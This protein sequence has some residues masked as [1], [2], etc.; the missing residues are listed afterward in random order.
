MFQVKKNLIKIKLFCFHCFR[1]R[2]RQAPHRPTESKAVYTEDDAVNTAEKDKEEINQAVIK[3]KTSN[4]NSAA[5]A[6]G[7]AGEKHKIG[8]I[9]ARYGLASSPKQDQED[10]DSAGVT[11]PFL[12]KTEQERWKRELAAVDGKSRNS[13]NVPQEENRYS[14]FKMAPSVSYNP[15]HESQTLDTDAL[16]MTSLS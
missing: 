6:A 7:A 11:D 4:T 8:E 14:S 16:N 12:R 2:L 5:A 10:W 15:K 9:C 1:W 3:S 13:K